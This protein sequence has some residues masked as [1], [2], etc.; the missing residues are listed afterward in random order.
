MRKNHLRFIITKL[1]VGLVIVSLVLS[2]GFNL[3][4]GRFQ[5][6]SALARDASQDAADPVYLPLVKNGHPGQSI[7]GIETRLE[8]EERYY[9]AYATKASWLRF[10]RVLWHEIEPQQGQRD[11]SQLDSL[12]DD[13]I[14][15]NSI[16][17][18][19][20]I[21]VR[22][23]PSWAQKVPGSFCGPIKEDAFDDFADFMHELVQQ[24]SVAPY[25]VN[26][27][28]MG[29]EPDATVNTNPD[30]T[31][32]C[33][34]DPDD[35]LYYGGGYYGEMLEVVYPEIK[36]ADSGAQVLVGGLL[37]DCDPNNPPAGKDCTPSKFLEG[38][39]AQS[40]GDYFD[41]VSF[42]AYDFYLGTLGHYSNNN[43]HSSWDTTG[44]AE[45]AKAEYLQNLLDS[46]QVTGKELFNTET[47]LVC[48]NAGICNVDY[49]KT[50]AYFLVKSYVHAM[51][52]E[53][54]A[55]VWYDMYGFWRNSGLFY[56]F[57]VPRR[58]FLAYESAQ[59]RFDGKSFTQEIT[60]YGDV[61]VFEF[62]NDYK[63]LW[64][65]WAMDENTHNITL[66][67]S[68]DSA[69]NA[70]GVPLTIYDSLNVDF[71]PVYVEWNK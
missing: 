67:S 49:E 5:F 21:I 69:W 57:G 18:N 66:P 36:S 44:P 3:R 50:K 63:Q 47:A 27:Y 48:D 59:K 51:I 34:G 10:N 22:G 71:A 39:L 53:F 40:G 29:N 61:K 15:A 37:L 33:W 60:S 7:F 23:T 30:I 52:R 35:T 12:K 46:Y 26:Y 9:D 43:W 1:I 8:P 20:I 64:V 70:L 13:I 25:D 68:P 2:I 17:M 65:M 6:P 42:H 38:I 62:E 31:F 14:R 54:K 28:E 56:V 58:A 11:W 4:Q 55:N 45:I 19:A 41:A 24:L 32:G 16:N